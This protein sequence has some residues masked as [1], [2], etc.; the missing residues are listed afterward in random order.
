MNKQQLY[1][2]KLVEITDESITLY[3]YY[4]PSLTPKVIL[5]SKIENINV[6]KPTIF[7]GKWRIH[8]TGN[9]RTWYPF[10]SLRPKRDRIFFISFKDKWVQSAFT[11]ENAAEVE[12]ILKRKK[13]IK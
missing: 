13:L 1:K 4:F 9:F 10:D 2:D 6:R 8:G 5:F 3:K 12:L 7:S 11:A